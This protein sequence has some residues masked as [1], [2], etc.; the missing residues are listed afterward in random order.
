MNYS[1]DPEFTIEQEFSALRSRVLLAVLLLCTEAALYTGLLD[2]GD[3]LQRAGA[4]A[5]LSLTALMIWSTVSRFSTRLDVLSR[6][7]GEQCALKEQT[8]TTSKIQERFIRNFLTFDDTLHPQLDRIVEHTERASHQ[9]IDRVSTLAKTANQLVDHLEKA[10]YNSDDLEQEV[11]KRSSSTSQ[12]VVKLKDRLQSDQ[13]KIGNLTERIQSMTGKVG[14]ITQIAEQTNLL[15]LNAA[16]E[17]ARAGE[18]GRGFA[19]VA[20]EV[21]KLARTAAS[22]AQEIETAMIDA[23]KTIESGFDQDYRKEAEADAQEAHD[24]LKIIHKLIEGY[25]E[26]QQFHKNLMTEMTECNASFATEIIAVLAD[27]QFQDVVRQAVERMQT[28]L[29]K[30]N[31]L[32][33][34]MTQLVEQD[35]LTADQADRLLAQ[36]ECLRQDYER[37]ENRHQHDTPPDGSHIVLF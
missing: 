26:A 1:A 23:R 35:A 13:K 18:S 16:I 11:I 12:L 27:I 5:V 32:S 28:T 24:A 2:T 37:E 20:D 6:R 3:T 34:R 17:A 33:D 22:V 25:G 14:M 7:L 4:F 30:R 29:N 21:R 19:V 31:E 15:A 36:L 8:L 10:R 9:I